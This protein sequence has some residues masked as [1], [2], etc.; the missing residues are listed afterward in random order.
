MSYIIL[1][2]PLWEVAD[3]AREHMRERYAHASVKVEKPIS[4]EIEH[5]PTLHAK[6]TN[7][8]F[9]CVEVV[10][11]LEETTYLRFIQA[12]QKHTFPVLLLIA[13]PKENQT[14]TFSREVNNARLY[15]YSIWVV[16]TINGKIEE[17]NSPLSLSLTGLRMCD[18]KRLSPKYLE[19]ILS[20]EQTYL[21][22][23]PGKGCSAVYDQIEHVLR[24]AAFKT[25]KAGYWDSTLSK[26]DDLKAKMSWANVIEA[27]K[28]HIKPNKASVDG[29]NISALK[30][31]L[32]DRLNGIT[33]YRNEVNHTPKSL[34]KL[35]ER[36]QRLR[37]RMESAVDLYQELVDAVK[38][39]NLRP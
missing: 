8:H 30:P 7:H 37:T 2:A 15:G 32:F 14:R 36:D 4:I 13:L 19:P 24:L 38:C 27:F 39:L 22:G 35:I 17:M 5:T 10:S 20:G 26:P 16:D 3:L 6:M 33:E 11:S 9:R 12:C 28:K 29:K 1:P 23:D 18:R 25:Y 21:N 31:V 34:K